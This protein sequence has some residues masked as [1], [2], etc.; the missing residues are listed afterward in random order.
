MKFIKI[1]FI[2]L[3][4][5]LFSCSTISK[6]NNNKVIDENSEKIFITSYN[7]FGPPQLSSHLIGNKWWQW[8]DPENHQPVTYNVKVVVYKDVSLDA[9]KKAFPVIAKIKQDYRYVSYLEARNYFDKQFKFFEQE[10]REY[11]T[12]EQI[13]EVCSFPLA[14]YQTALA[15]ERKLK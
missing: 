13:G 5:I 3:S 6:K 10:M 1:L 2:F 11:S 14:L 9:V 8:D 12:P 4:M 15:M 7:S